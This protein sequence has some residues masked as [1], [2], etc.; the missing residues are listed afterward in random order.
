MKLFT[1]VTWSPANKLWVVDVYAYEAAIK[2]PN[3]A[4]IQHTI[5]LKHS[6]YDQYLSLNIM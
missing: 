3:E 2:R 5:Y 4:G 6:Q 1:P